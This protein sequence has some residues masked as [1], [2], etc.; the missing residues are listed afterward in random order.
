MRLN[1]TLLLKSNP[2]EL[3]QPKETSTYTMWYQR[4]RST[5][6]NKII[7]AVFLSVCC[8][9]VC[10]GSGWEREREQSQRASHGRLC[11]RELNDALRPA[12]TS[13]THRRRRTCDYLPLHLPSCGIISL[14]EPP[15]TFTHVAWFKSPA[16]ERTRKKTNK[17][18]KNTADTHDLQQRLLRPNMWKATCVQAKILRPSAQAF[19]LPLMKLVRLHKA[20]FLSRFCDGRLKNRKQEAIG[21]H[22]A[23]G[24]SADSESCYCANNMWPTLKK[25]LNPS[26]DKGRAVLPG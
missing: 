8:E 18:H 4:K 15:R 6:Q 16:A 20:P 1:I 23:V 3:G 10:G 19:Q 21:F 5:L 24:P 2:D 11:I 25:R 7:L 22:K 13:N 12:Q 26:R 17:C 9:Q 14:F